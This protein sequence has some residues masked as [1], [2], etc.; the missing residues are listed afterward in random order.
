M[1]GTKALNR[2]RL[3]R[4]IA[5]ILVFKTGLEGDEGKERTAEVRVAARELHGAGGGMHASGM[6]VCLLLRRAAVT[7]PP[8]SPSLPA[9]CIDD[10]DRRSSRSSDLLNNLH[11][12][13]PQ[14]TCEPF[15]SLGQEA[16]YWRP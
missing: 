16:R 6:W 2:G 9:G 1:T 14:E 3:S 8:S 12:H 13:L 10:S 11:I 7:S 5:D 15:G 4:S